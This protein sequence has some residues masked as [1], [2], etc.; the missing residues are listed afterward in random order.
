MIKLGIG[1]DESEFN[2]KAARIA[3][4]VLG[5]ADEYFRHPLKGWSGMKVPFAEKDALTIK[6]REPVDFSFKAGVLCL[7]ATDTCDVGVSRN[8][9]FSKATQLILTFNK[10][11]VWSI[12]VEIYGERYKA[13]IVPNTFEFASLFVP[14]MLG[15]LESA[16]ISSAHGVAARWF[17]EVLDAYKAAKRESTH[18]NIEDLYDVGRVVDRFVL[19]LLH[20]NFGFSVRDTVIRF[21]VR[22]RDGAVDVTVANL[23][24]IFSNRFVESFAIY[25]IAERKLVYVKGNLV[26]KV[27]VKLPEKLVDEVAE[28]IKRVI[29]EYAYVLAALKLAYNTF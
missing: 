22:R 9:V 10:G 11:S 21:D 13:E 14:D 26:K 5:I 25:S 28:F 29:N 20:L 7:E 3:G 27:L 15:K 1:A 2:E 6:F 16:E 17:A 12:E 18:V 24:P 19:E 4:K 8:F 23:A